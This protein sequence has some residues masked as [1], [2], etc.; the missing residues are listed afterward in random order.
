ME[1]QRNLQKIAK[2]LNLANEVK[3]VYSGRQRNSI[4]IPTMHKLDFTNLSRKVLNSFRQLSINYPYYI[5][6]SLIFF[7]LIEYGSA[8]HVNFH[9]KFGC[10]KPL[11]KYSRKP[12]RTNIMII[13][14][15][16]FDGNGRF[17]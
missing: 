17:L 7:I 1:F 15:R 3:G 9:P 6:A 13:T 2:L 11:R 12:D 4:G 16:N 8:A 10:K 14:C 5:F